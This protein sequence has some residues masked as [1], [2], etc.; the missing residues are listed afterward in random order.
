[1]RSASGGPRQRPSARRSSYPQAT[2][3]QVKRAIVAS[4]TPGPELLTVVACGG[5]VNAAAALDTLGRSL[6]PVP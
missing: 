6:G 2:A 4:C 5:I 3:A 1:V